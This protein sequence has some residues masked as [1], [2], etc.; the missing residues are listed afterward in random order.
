[1]GWSEGQSLGKEGSGP[2]EPV[3]LNSYISVYLNKFIIISFY[4]GFY[5]D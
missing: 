4:I 5:S 2:T 1:M 3:S